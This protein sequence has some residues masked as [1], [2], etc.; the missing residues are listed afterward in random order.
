MKKTLYAA[1]ASLVLMGAC[2]S[3]PKAEPNVAEILNP[4]PAGQFA[5]SWEK[6]ASDLAQAEKRF[7]KAEKSVEKGEKIVKDARKSLRKGEDLIEDGRADM[8]KAERQIAAAKARQAEIK[9]ASEVAGS[10]EAA[11]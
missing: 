10:V 4:A 2:A 5:K 11:S 1:L 8:R 3:A 6:A 7:A 9:A